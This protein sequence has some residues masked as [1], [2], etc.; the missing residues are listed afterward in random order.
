MKSLLI[1][2]ALVMFFLAVQGESK[3]IVKTGW[4]L[5]ALPVIAYNSDLGL[6]YGL[7]LNLVDFGDGSHYPNYNRKLYLEA[8][9]YTKGSG[10][11]RFYYDAPR[12]INNIRLIADVSWLPDRAYDFLGFNGYEAVYNTSWEDQDAPD[13]RTRMFYKY[14]RNLFRIKADLQGKLKSSRVK[15]TAGLT[16]QTFDIS[17]VDVDKLNKGKDEQDRLPNV[18]GLYQK[19]LNWGFIPEGEKNGGHILTA[20]A[21][22]IYDSRDVI[23]APNRGIWTEAVVVVS[24]EALASDFSFAKF[25]FTHRQYFPLMPNRLTLAYRLGYQT[26]FSGKT[27]FFYLP[28]IETSEMQAAKSEGLGGDRFTRGIRRNRIIGEGIFFGNVELRYK[29]LRF[30]ALKQNFYIGVNPFLD[31]GQVIKKA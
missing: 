29:L 24:S 10:I 26:T 13:Y 1:T 15:W 20:K 16:S 2:A 11:Y 5:G 25:S 8:S 3:D 6:E 22:L 21:G 4:N 19:Y 28:M 7:L 27:P 31:F 18:E 14:D 9:A 12:F 30:T 23:A 17:A